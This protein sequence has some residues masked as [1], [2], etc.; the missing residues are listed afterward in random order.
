MIDYSLAAPLSDD[1]VDVI[2]TKSG[3]TLTKQD[4]TTATLNAGSP[5][6]LVLDI[7]T[8]DGVTWTWAD[9]QAATTGLRLDFV[10]NGGT[11]GP[12]LLVDAFGFRVA[13]LPAG[14]FNE[15]TTLSPVPLVDNYDPTKLR[16][17]SASVAPTTVDT[18]TGTI[19][20]SDVGPINGGDTTQIEVTFNVISSTTLT[21]SYNVGQHRQLDDQHVRRRHPCEQRDRHRERHRHPAGHDLRHRVGRGTGGTT[22]WVGATG[23]EV[24]HRLRP[25]HRH[26]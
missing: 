3:T 23:V 11:D 8:L 21:A 17:V 25:P 26:G 6:Q 10:K 13:A 20:W 24:G 7:T 1:D 4:I 5:G 16:F 9:L 18:G 15:A 12:D 19:T 2:V 14:G 22:G